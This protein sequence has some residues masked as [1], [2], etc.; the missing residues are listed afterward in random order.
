MS[1]NYISAA[2]MKLF[3]RLPSY[4][5]RLEHKLAGSRVRG[6]SELPALLGGNCLKATK[7]LQTMFADD[8]LETE[9]LRGEPFADTLASRKIRGLWH[10]I[11]RTKKDRT[12]IDP[13]YGQFLSD[14]G[15][16]MVGA[17]RD[18]AFL[19][20]RIALIPEGQEEY[21]G[22]RFVEHARALRQRWPKKIASWQETARSIEDKD[23]ADIWNPNHYY[24]I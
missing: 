5:T 7:L 24:K 4:E 13:T 16:D 14:G 1:S 9:R 11:L 2:Q 22:Q 6:R 18:S 15:V 23:I 12:I 19:Q 20:R 21:F 3:E 8:G 17:S 10:C